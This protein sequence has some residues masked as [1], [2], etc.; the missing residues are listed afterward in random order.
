MEL[1]NKIALITGSSKGIGESTAIALSKE[2]A[3][4]IVNYR[5]DSDSANSVLKECNKYS[6]GNLVVQADITKDQEIQQM[7]SKISSTFNSIDILVN[8]AGIYDESSN[9]NDAKVFE[10]IFQTNFLG[11]VKITEQFLKYCKKGKI[12][13]V[14]SI[15]GKLG[16]GSPDGIAYSSLKAGLNSYTKILAKALAP[17]ILVNAVAPGKTL[18]PEWGVLSEEDKIRIGNT[19]LIERFIKPEEIADA[20]LFLLKNDA[21]CG[22]ILSIDGGMSLKTLN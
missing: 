4:V 9:R 6:Q 11:Q 2:G 8:N 16:H 3:T 12:V 13:N 21:M 17:N 10:K 15:H 1:R 18:T 14:S 7:F 19:Q 5:N 22:E 20:V